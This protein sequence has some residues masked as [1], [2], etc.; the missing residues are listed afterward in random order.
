M[1]ETYK[2]IADAVWAGAQAIGQQIAGL[3]GVKGA[4]DNAGDSIAKASVSFTEMNQTLETGQ[5]VLDGFKQGFEFAEE[6]AQIQATERQFNALAESIDTTAD[7]LLNQLTPA[8]GGAIS[9][10]E[11]MQLTNTLL[12]SGLATTGDEAFTL[13]DTIN[14]IKKPTDD[15]A[16]AVENFSLLIANQ[17]KARLDSF[18]ISSA[19]V[20]KTMEELEKTMAGASKEQ[21]FFEATMREAEG[22]MRRMGTEA[23][24]TVDAFTKFRVES[25]NLTN[26]LKILAADA[27]TPAVEAA[28][29][30]TAQLL[31]LKAVSEES[32]KSNIAFNVGVKEGTQTI[33]ALTEVTDELTASNV[34]FVAGVRLGIE[35]FGGI[36]E[37]TESATISMSAWEARVQG[38]DAASFA[39][40]ERVNALVASMDEYKGLAQDS[41]AATIEFENV[42][43]RLAAAEQGAE[44]AL[45]KTKESLKDTEPLSAYQLK[46][47]EIKEAVDSGKLSLDDAK[48]ATDQFKKNLEFDEAKQ[49]IDEVRSQIETLTRAAEKAAQQRLITFIVDVQNGISN[50]GGIGGA[51]QIPEANTFQSQG[52]T[53]NII[54]NQNNFNNPVV[55]PANIFDDATALGEPI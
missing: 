54:T 32:G 40:N 31:D 52:I 3:K 45:K 2:I 27:L 14:K 11:L 47:Q 26:E 48:T 36:E 5:K 37:A 23:G 10:L 18:N 43:D 53:T 4:A 49:G 25:S 28:G 38:A 17:S 44:E 51:G 39:F 41:V 7:V 9:N 24:I 30:L 55:P 50:L 8:T 13:I 33:A 46:L 42:T 20:T 1:A 16:S 35:A 19:N 6:G 22:T 15:L 29:G 12:A 34:A 21:I